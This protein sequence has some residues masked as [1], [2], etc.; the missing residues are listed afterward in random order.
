MGAVTRDS[1]LY[2]NVFTNSFVS[3][4][5]D[6]AGRAVPLPFEHTVAAGGELIGDIVNLTELPFG[7]EVV[8]L[9]LITDGIASTLEIGDVGDTNRLMLGTDLTAAEARGDI[10]FAGMRFRPVGP[11]STVV[12]GTWSVGNPAAGGIFKGRIWIIPGA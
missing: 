5:R 6:R 4:A 8:G 9:E 11:G 10:A 2:G 12:I 7:S 1:V 3:D